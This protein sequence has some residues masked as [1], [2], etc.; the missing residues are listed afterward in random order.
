MQGGS[1]LLGVKLPE[2][3][4]PVE[5]EPRGAL[6]RVRPPAELFLEMHPTIDFG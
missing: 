5:V 2:N 4:R 6:A 1:R 3:A